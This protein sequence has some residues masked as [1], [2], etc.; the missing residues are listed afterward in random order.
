MAIDRWGA[1]AL[2]GGGKA[3]FGG[4]PWRERMR[5]LRT[6]RSREGIGVER[7]RVVESSERG[8]C[9]NVASVMASCSAV[10]GGGPCCG[11]GGAFMIGCGEARGV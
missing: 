11:G 7:V 3:T 2:G 5:A 9:W 6:V 10:G 1:I 8:T 4:R